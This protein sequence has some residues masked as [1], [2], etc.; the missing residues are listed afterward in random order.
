MHAAGLIA[1]EVRDLQ[2]ARKHS[3]ERG[4]LP[5][6]AEAQRQFKANRKAW[7]FF[8]AQPPGYRKIATWWVMSAKKSDTRV[9]RLEALIRDSRAGLRLPD[10][11]RQKD[12]WSKEGQR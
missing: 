5:F 8:E 10:F 11:R 1:F 9:R 4:S 7:A 12:G 6:D 2:R 3:E